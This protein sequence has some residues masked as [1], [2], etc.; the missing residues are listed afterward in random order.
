MPADA[1][2]SYGES[3]NFLRDLQVQLAAADVA[4]PG[5][6]TGGAAGAG[7]PAPERWRCSLTDVWSEG[8][9]EVPPPPAPP[10]SY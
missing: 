2:Q 10:L 7:A 8:A 6:R 9:A 5:R 3:F 4:L 1:A